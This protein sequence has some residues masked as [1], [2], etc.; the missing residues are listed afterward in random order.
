MKQRG[1]TPLEIKFILGHPDYIIKR[2]A[3]GKVT[4]VGHLKGRTIKIVYT[5]KENYLNIVTIM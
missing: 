1:I 4:A 2:T 3:E 5:N